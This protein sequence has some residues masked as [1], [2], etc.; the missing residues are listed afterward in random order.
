MENQYVVSPS[1]QIISVGTGWDQHALSYDAP[2][3]V[4]KYILG[5]Y[6]WEF[7]SGVQTRSYLNAIFFACRMDNQI[8]STLCRCDAPDE[9]ILFR[10]TVCPQEDETLIVTHKHIRAS[11][12]QKSGFVNGLK[13]SVDTER[14]SVCCSFRLGENWI[15]PFFQ[16][17]TR[18]FAQSYGVCPNCRET[19]LAELGRKERPNQGSLNVVVPFRSRPASDE[20]S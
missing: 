10:F 1:G 13:A 12:F 18:Y 11:E 20:T 19:T 8:F 3:A 16:P 5:R 14:C 17:D 6:W 2:L 7:V 15:D 4:S 9:K